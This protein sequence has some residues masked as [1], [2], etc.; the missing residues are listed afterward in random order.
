[1]KEQSKLKKPLLYAF[2]LSVIVG[3]VFGI[4][5]VLRDSWGWLEVRVILTT[6][7]IAAASVC[8]LASDVC[9]T[10][11]G[12]NVLPTIG[13]TLTGLAAVLLLFGIWTEIGEDTFWKCTFCVCTFCVATVHVCLLSIAKLTGKFRWVYFVGS[14]IIFGF[15]M[16]LSLIVFGEIDL[17]D[18]WRYIAAIS[19][20]IAAITLVIPILH[21]ISRIEGER[22]E[23]LG[24]LE[25]RNLTAIDQQIAELETRITQLKALRAQLLN[26]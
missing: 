21:R 6:A 7:V 23:L 17:D 5:L 18:V 24:P 12:R 15:A 9:R 3:A 16:M 10:P 19:I 2:I 8:G 1:M 22:A 4:V 13:L 26:D 25:A 20:L 14:Q 11:L